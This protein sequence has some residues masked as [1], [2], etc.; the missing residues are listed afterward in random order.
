LTTKPD[1]G[2]GGDGGD[3][4]EPRMLISDN[5]EVVLAEGRDVERFFGDVMYDLDCVGC[6]DNHDRLGRPGRPGGPGGPG[7]PGRPGRLEK[8]VYNVLNGI[9]NVNVNDNMFSDMKPK[10]KSN[11]N[12]SLKKCI[13][14]EKDT[15]TCIDC[16]DDNKRILRKVY[17]SVYTDNVQL[18]NTVV[19]M[20]PKL[21]HIRDN[22]HYTN[23]TYD[24][25]YIEIKL[26]NAF[27][28][29]MDK[30]C[31]DIGDVVC[32]T[33]HWENESISR[34]IGKGRSD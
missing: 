34:R 25:D 6:V 23:H 17:E 4:G 19:T 32:Y 2:S 8:V 20:L 28:K 3:G 7:R 27:K 26:I 15:V 18:K 12:Y 30:S 24:T 31:V 1:A 5:C 21:Y 33:I 11:N 22:D 13:I 14:V 10:H 29:Y 9:N 16:T